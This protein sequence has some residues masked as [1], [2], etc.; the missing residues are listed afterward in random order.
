MRNLKTPSSVQ[1][2]YDLWNDAL[3]KADQH[4][5][6]YEPAYS[7]AAAV[8]A[9][10]EQYYYSDYAPHIHY[11]NALPFALPTSLRATMCGA[12]VASTA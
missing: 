7:Q 9:F 6:D 5:I 4:V 10:E 2:Y 12:T 1:A 11:A 3:Q 8:K